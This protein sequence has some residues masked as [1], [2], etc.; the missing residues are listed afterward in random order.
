MFSICLTCQIILGAVARSFDRSIARSKTP[1]VVQPSC[2]RRRAGRVGRSEATRA[3]H[4]MSRST[5]AILGLMDAR[6][7][8]PKWPQ[9]ICMLSPGV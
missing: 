7:E 2:R 1:S 4:C 3:L 5:L 9:S 8:K 6:V